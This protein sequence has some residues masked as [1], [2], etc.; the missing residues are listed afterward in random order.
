M[1]TAGDSQVYGKQILA[2]GGIIIR[3]GGLQFHIDPGPGALVAAKKAGINLREN[4]AV[5]VSHNHILHS[6]DVNAV[7]S[8]MTHAGIDKHGILIAEKTVLEGTFDQTPTIGKF[9]T[10]CVERVIK[11]TPDKKIGINEIEI[12]TTPVK[13][14]GQGGVGFK[15][16]TPN[17]TLSYVGDTNYFAE[18]SSHHENSDIL[19]LNIVGPSGVKTKD[20]MNSD[21]AIKLLKKVKSRLAIITHFGTKMISSDPL[22]E[23]RHIQKETGVQ[24]IAAKDFMNIKPQS[25]SAMLKQ[26]TLNLY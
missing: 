13:H 17:F 14:E 6:N 24:V 22:A 8:A 21:D 4:T 3:A 15:F 1:G 5:L 20:N 10:G 19:I 11:V 16:F 7:I 18:L 23:A 25:Y 9:F 26:R 12:Q 2:S